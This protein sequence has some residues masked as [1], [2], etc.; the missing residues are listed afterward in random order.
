MYK[1]RIRRIY[2]PY[3]VNDGYRI[4]IDRLWPRGMSKEKAKEDEWAKQIAPSPEIRK[5]FNHEPAKMDQFRQQY[6]YE[7]DHNEDAAKFVHHVCDQLTRSNVTLL[8]AARDE[9]I[10][11]A[12]ILQQWL[13]AHE[14]HMRNIH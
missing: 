6:R 11:H 4:L 13:E 2:E 7:L 5:W 1:L 9:T 12:V 10:N 14:T 3:S 8:Y